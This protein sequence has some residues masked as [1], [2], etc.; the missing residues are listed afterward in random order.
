MLDDDGDSLGW[1]KARVV[2][3]SIFG[4]FTVLL[5][6]LVREVL[7]PFMLAAIIAY[8]LTPLVTWGETRIRLSRPLSIAFVYAIVLGI[9][10]LFVAVLAPMLMRETV[11]LVREAPRMVQKAAL[12][13]GP[14]VDRRVNGFLGQL[15][16]AAAGEGKPAE[17]RSPTLVIEPR[18]GGAYAVVLGDGVE[19]VEESQGHYR[20][21]DQGALPSGRF[22]LTAALDDAFDRLVQYIETNAG[23]V[24]K[25]G[26]QIVQSTTRAIFVL[27]MV[28]MVAGYLMYTREAILGFFRS[29]TPPIHRP[30]FERLILR[31]DRGLAGV[32]RG[33]LLICLVNGLL[34]AI[35]FWLFDLKYWHVLTLVATVLSIIPIFGAILSTVPAILVG[36][37]Q[38][39]GTAVWVLV[40]IIGIHQI[41]ANLLN[42]KIIGVAAKLHPVLIVFSLLVGEHFFGIWGAL[43]AVPVLSLVQS[44]FNHFRFG[45]PDAPPD[46]LRPVAPRGRSD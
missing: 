1:T 29:L 31:M 32:V 16:A 4:A 41:E 14:E 35:G 10:G 34:S 22:E 43:L 33:Q 11:G 13:Y 46:S 23:G 25:L 27:F 2:F 37:T 38:S 15:P 7:L 8:V 3:L 26:Q 24:F 19:I 6:L 5:L 18:E 9:L 28:L 42:P 44:I 30:S 40:W 36:L 45:L 20:V 39:F 21:W 12:T 17:P